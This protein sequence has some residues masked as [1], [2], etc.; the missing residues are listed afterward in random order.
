M[1]KDK[2]F[3]GIVTRWHS[4]LGE[5]ALASL[6]CHILNDND[7]SSVFREN[8]VVKGLFDVPLYDYEMHKD[9]THWSWIYS[10][11]NIPIILQHIARVE[12]WLGI[13]ITIDKRRNHVP[14]IFRKMD[15]PEY[16]V[17][18]NTMTGRHTPLK[19]WPYFYELTRLFKKAGIRYLDLDLHQK[20]GIECLN[21]V[22][23]AHL[24]LGLDTG[25]PHYVSKFANGKTLIISGGFVTPEFWASLYDFEFIQ[26]EDV[27]CRP[28]YINRGDV[29][30][31]L[32]ECGG[33]HM[34]MREISP[35]MVFERVYG[36][37]EK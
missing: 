28:C 37:L 14:V 4:G 20:R 13:S 2:D 7:V 11:N 17:V 5:P 31:N 27:P 3:K 29:E 6:F 8:R 24:F 22:K 23:K 25:M 9:W 30:K 36:R 15:V 18:M 16:D 10:L 32:R 26:I 1:Y 35:R 12:K 33:N 19:E 34:C 21:L